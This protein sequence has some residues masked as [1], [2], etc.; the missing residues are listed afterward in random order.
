[1][2]CNLIEACKVPHKDISNEEGIRGC[3]SI[4]SEILQDISMEKLNDYACNLRVVSNRYI[5]NT[6]RFQF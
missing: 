4:R 1:M 5:N 2:K 6:L 3:A